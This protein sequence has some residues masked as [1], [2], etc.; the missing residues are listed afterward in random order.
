[1]EK[2]ENKIKIA[3]LITAYHSYDHLKKLISA[4]TD[5]NVFFYIHIDKNSVIP[6]NLD[7]FNNIQFIKRH[8]VWW[9]GWSHQKAILNLMAEAFKENYDYYALISG[10]DYPIKKNDFLYSKLNEGGEFISIKEGFPS[11]MKK[12]WVTRFY[13]D[14]FYR[15]K[16]NKPI[17]IKILLKIEKNISLYFPKKNFP[18]QKV[19]F[20]PTWWVLSHSTVG[21]ILEFLDSHPEYERFFRNSYCSEEILIPTIIGNSDI[22]NLKGNLTYVDWSVD[23]GPAYIS[24]KHLNIFESNFVHNEMGD[25]ESFFARKFKNDSQELLQQIDTN[26]RS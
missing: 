15:R 18:F 20:G 6:T 7:D 23:P 11:E 1:M 25:N 14:L 4:L 26:L 16:P 9:A 24:E 13:F 5:N 22:G 10:S 8:K 12:S 2:I 17:W 3:Y 19:F 21:Y